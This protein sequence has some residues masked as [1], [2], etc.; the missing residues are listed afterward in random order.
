MEIPKI[1]DPT[2]TENKWYKHWMDN[3]YFNSKPDE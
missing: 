1:Y 3:G 2:I